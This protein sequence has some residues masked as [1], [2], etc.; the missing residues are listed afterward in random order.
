[1]VAVAVKKAAKAAEK[2]AAKAAKGTSAAPRERNAPKKEKEV[3]AKEPEEAPYVNTTPKG[4]KK[5]ELSLLSSRPST[6]GSSE[7]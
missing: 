7:G 6:G 1:L 2:A 3:K 4:E 5:G